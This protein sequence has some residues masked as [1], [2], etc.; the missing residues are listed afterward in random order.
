MVAL[1][2]AAQTRALDG[3]SDG[4]AEGRSLDPRQSD[5]DPT[6]FSVTGVSP[7]RAPGAPAPEAVIRRQPAPRADERAPSAGS[8]SVDTRSGR[9]KPDLLNVP[10]DG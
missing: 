2:M 9:S 8:R 3:V 5:G 10:S 1:A 6:C 7:T 4:S